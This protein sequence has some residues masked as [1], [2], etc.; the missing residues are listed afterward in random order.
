MTKRTGSRTVAIEFDGNVF[1]NNQFCEAFVKSIPMMGMERNIFFANFPVVSKLDGQHMR[2]V[3]DFED[4]VIET[5]HLTALF[6]D[7][8]KQVCEEGHKPAGQFGFGQTPGLPSG[9]KL[10]FQ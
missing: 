10:I 4:P 6:A 7:A 2:V 3:F 5:Y 1:P 9:F 8:I